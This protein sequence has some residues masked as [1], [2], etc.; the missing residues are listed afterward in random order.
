MSDGLIKVLGLILMVM[1]LA[2]AIAFSSHHNAA[3]QPRPEP[4]QHGTI[5]PDPGT[6]PP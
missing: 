4:A 3:A 5:F 6:G 2:A 1:G